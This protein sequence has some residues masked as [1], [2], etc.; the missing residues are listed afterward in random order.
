MADT[1]PEV[2]DERLG[3]QLDA[4][5]ESFN[6]AFPGGAPEQAMPVTGCYVEE[7]YPDYVIVECGPDKFKVPYST[8][9]AGVITFVPRAEWVKV[10]EVTTYQEVKKGARNARTDQSHLNQAHDHLVAAG[11]QCAGGKSFSGDEMVW[12]GDEIKAI[13]TGDTMKLSGYLVRFSTAEDP[14]LTGD[15][16]T[17][18]TDFG[19]VDEADVYFHH[20]QPITYKGHVL[21]YDQRITTAKLIKD[22]VGI[23]AEAILSLSDEYQAMFGEM[24][25]A[26]RLGWSSGTAPHLVKRESVGKAYQITRWPLGDDA[27]LTPTPA[28]KRNIVVPLKSLVT[29]P[30]I[31]AE[32]AQS[33]QTDAGGENQEPIH[34]E[35]KSMTPEE[36]AAQAEMLAGVADSAADKAVKSLIKTLPPKD[37]GGTVVVITDEADRPFKTIAAQVMAVKTFELSKGREVAPRIKYLLSEGMKAATGASEGVPTDGGILLDP[38]LSADILKPVHETG[39]Y[40]SAVRRLP[41]SANSNYGYIN[42]V[43]ETSRASGSRWGGIVGYHRA[44]AGAM[45]GSKPKFRRINWELKAYDVLVYATDE[46]LAD[47]TQF[48]AVVEQGMN[49]EIAFM[50]N[51]DLVNGIGTSG[52]Q[53]ILNSGAL[54]SVLR[55]TLLNVLHAD[56]LAMWQRLDS[57][58]KKSASWYINSEV[59]P[60]LDALYFTGATSVL[61]PYIGYRPDGVMTIYGRPVVETEFNAALGTVGDIVLADM[62]QY[63]FW[64]KSTPEK[65]VNLWLAWLTGETAVRLTYRCDGQSSIASPLT[66]YKG[67]NTQSCFVALAT[68][69]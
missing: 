34:K 41:V 16:F 4:V 12:G 32:A 50:V 10:E 27:S 22:D 35:N 46:L 11:A 47:S 37:D 3:D 40:S 56:I 68:R 33:A 42:G 59:Q 38:T 61:S 13:K 29:I 18:D 43:D 9:A 15:F 5:R 49:E 67:T 28:E 51:D 65:S 58:S 17:K 69:S 26:K 31:E 54:I 24:A 2:K 62:S 14:D 63:L 1:A 30:Q 6:A 20:C 25:A 21:K 55:N 57:R 53:G 23:L 7:V 36:L 48:S 60:Q 39:P 64:E 45:T 52:P 44:E 66:P 8:D 19:K